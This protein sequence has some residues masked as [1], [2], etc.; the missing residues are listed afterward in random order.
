ML[1][2]TRDFIMQ[3]ERLQ[4]VL[5]GWGLGSRRAIE[6]WI[7]AGEV[8]VNGEVATLGTRVTPESHPVVGLNHSRPLNPIAPAP[9]HPLRSPLPELCHHSPGG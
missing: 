3:G 7:A 6:Q 4:K 1:T 2:L 8:S 9:L 5:A